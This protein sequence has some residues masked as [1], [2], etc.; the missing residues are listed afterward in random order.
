[1]QTLVPIGTFESKAMRL[2]GNEGYEGLLA[3]IARNPKAGVV[4]PGLGGLRK[5]R[6]SRPGIGTRGGTRVIYYFHDELNPIFLFLI[7]AKADQEDMTPSQSRQLKQLVNNLRGE[8]ARSND[9]G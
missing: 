4:V 6:Y 1:M 5:L 2:L 8:I 3:H 7:Y 9:N